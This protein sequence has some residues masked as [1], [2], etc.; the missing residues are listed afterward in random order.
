LSGVFITMIRHSLRVS[1]EIAQ[2][3]G[4]RGIFQLRYRF[5]K[6]AAAGLDTN[7]LCSPHELIP[8]ISDGRL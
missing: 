7:A 4:T 8:P 6:K 1:H 5:N 3:A 2:A